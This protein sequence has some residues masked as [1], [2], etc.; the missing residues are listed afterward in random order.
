M[1]ELKIVFK[2]THQHPGTSILVLLQLLVRKGS[3]CMQPQSQQMVWSDV[4][5]QRNVGLTMS[6]FLE[7]KGKLSNQKSKLDWS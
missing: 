7:H 2:S 4:L 5:V 6:T 1:P 3:V